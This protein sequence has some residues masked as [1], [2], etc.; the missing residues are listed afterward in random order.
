[1]PPALMCCCEPQGLL[2]GDVRQVVQGPAPC[3]CVLMSTFV[4]VRK[5]MRDWTVSYDKWSAE[6]VFWIVGGAS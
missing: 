1:M 3:E 4:Q 5:D 2:L 6:M